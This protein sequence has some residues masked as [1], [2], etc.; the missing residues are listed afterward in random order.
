MTGLQLRTWVRL[1]CALTLGLGLSAAAPGSAAAPAHPR[2]SAAPHVQQ[3]VAGIVAATHAPES[4]RH[5]L[6][7][8]GAPAVTAGLAAGTVLVSCLLVTAVARRRS[9]ARAGRRTTTAGSRAPP[10]AIGSWSHMPIRPNSGLP[11]L[12]IKTA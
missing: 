4:V 12:R 9:S 5:S 11:C 6:H 10:V 7:R 8:P 1:L 2:P 3:V